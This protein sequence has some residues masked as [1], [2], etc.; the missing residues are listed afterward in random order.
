MGIDFTCLQTVF[1]SYIVFELSGDV[2][3]MLNI[4]KKVFVKLF[5]YKSQMTRNPFEQNL[6]F[7]KHFSFFNA[8]LQSLTNTK[9]ETK[10]KLRCREIYDIVDKYDV[11]TIVE[12]GTGRTTFLFNI[13]SGVNCISVEQDKRWFE[14]ID[15]I[16]RKHSLHAEIILSSVSAYKNGAS[17][18]ELPFVEPD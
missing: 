5:Y 17:F 3:L 18:D 6:T 9:L 16:L 8:E 4:I 11:K 14:I 15:R 2:Y 12:I 7:S 10:F 13:I 1:I